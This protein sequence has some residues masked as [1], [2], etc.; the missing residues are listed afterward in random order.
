[1]FVLYDYV[2]SSILFLHHFE[3]CEATSGLD[4]FE[5]VSRQGEI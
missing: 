2:A 3:V 4:H 5:Q 1:M